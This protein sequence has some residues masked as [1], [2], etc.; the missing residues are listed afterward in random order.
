MVDKPNCFFDIKINVFKNYSN[1]IRMMN[2]LD[3]CFNYFGILYH[4]LRKILNVCAQVKR[5]LE[6]WA[7]HSIT[8]IVN[9]TELFL[10]LW[11][12]EVI[13]QLVYI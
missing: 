3:W 2:H 1:Y 6:K 5:E 11:H 9:F 7:N 13:S 4:L 12:K 10:D 8:K